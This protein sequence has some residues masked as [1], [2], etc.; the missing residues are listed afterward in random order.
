[1]SYSLNKIN[2][3][4]SLLKELTIEDVRFI[5]ENLDEQ[6]KALNY[7]YRSINN[8]KSFPFLVLLNSLVSYQLSTKGEDYWWEFANYFSNK[9]LKDEVENIIKFIIESKG[10]KRFLSTKI[11]RLQKIKEYKDYIK[12]KYDYFYENMIELRNFLSNIF[13]QK[14]E[15]KTIV[16]SV[17]MFGYTMRIYTKKFIPYPFEIAIPVDSRIKKITKKFTDE[18]PISFWFKISKEVKIPPLHLDSILWTLF[19]KNYDELSSISFEKRN[20]LIEIARLVRE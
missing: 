7:L 8:K 5:E 1:M 20:I 3:L 6:Y 4:I 16:F 15:A 14:K 2:I 13:Q 12:N 11:K 19:G 18:N 17:K 9:D 10:N